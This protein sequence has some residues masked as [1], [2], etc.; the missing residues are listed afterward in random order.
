MEMINWILNMDEIKY[1]QRIYAFLIM[2]THSKATTEMLC[3]KKLILENTA[4][5]N[6]KTTEMKERI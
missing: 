1:D 3:W 5:S 4:A 6:T 2:D